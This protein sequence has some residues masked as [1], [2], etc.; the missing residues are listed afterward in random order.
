M[1]EWLRI[2]LRVVH[3]AAGIFWVGSSAFLHFYVEPTVHALGPQGGPFMRHMTETRKL[4]VFISISGVLTILAGV[5][6]YWDNSNGFDPDWI[7]SGP[8]LGFTVGAIA[9]ILAFVIG[10]AVVRPRVVRMGA[11]G[12]AMG[13][14]TPS[15]EQI[16]EMGALQRS[17]R[18]ISTVNIVLLAIAVVAMAVA[19]YL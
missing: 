12:G 13:S 2:A 9:A 5:A 7:T 1:H 11:L 3:I 16:Q 8:G 6:L 10:V 17:L 14:G 19:R 18:S 15:P 4:P